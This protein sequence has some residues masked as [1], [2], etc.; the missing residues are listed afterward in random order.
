MT[1]FSKKNCFSDLKCVP[2]LIDVAFGTLDKF[3]CI[4]IVYLG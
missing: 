3:G 4:W 1:Q 2:T